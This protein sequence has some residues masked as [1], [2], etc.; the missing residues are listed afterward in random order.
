MECTTITR[1]FYFQNEGFEV[2]YAKIMKLKSPLSS[3][4]IGIYHTSLLLETDFFFLKKKD[5]DPTV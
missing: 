4:H 5:L 1:E 3:E 2:T